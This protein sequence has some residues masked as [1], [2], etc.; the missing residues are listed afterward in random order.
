MFEIEIYEDAKGNSP[1]S[2]YFERLNEKAQTS[3]NERIRLKK[4][5]EYLELLKHH[6][7]RIG[8][9][10]TKHIG[11]KIWELRPTNDRILFA[12]WK[13]NTFILLHHFVKK[14]KKTPKS[15]IE[16][17]KHNLKDFLERSQ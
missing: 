12:H 13:G 16:K 7:T 1:I 8:L 5:S 4:I 17:A 10:V 9:P 2:D 15:E 3:K 11:D 14:T 6:G